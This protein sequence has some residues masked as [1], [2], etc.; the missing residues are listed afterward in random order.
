MGGSNYSSRS[1]LRR[2][3]LRSLTISLVASAAVRAQNGNILPGNNLI[4]DGIP[5][6]AISL[7]NT[8]A[9]YQESFADSLLG[10]DPVKP[11]MI[12]IRQR[13]QAWEIGRIA[14]AGESLQRFAY[15]P[16]GCYGTHYQPL[17]ESLIFRIDETSG[18]EVTQLYRY[19]I[20]TRSKTLLTDG[21]SRNLYP[22][23]SN[24]GEWLM[25]SS[26]RRN[27]KDLDIYVVKPSDPKS[28]RMIAQLD[29]EDWA[30]FDW[31]PD[32]RKAIISDYKSINE[33]YLWILDIESGKKTL[34]TPAQEGEKVFNG[35]NAQFSKDNKGVYHLTD[36][37]SE[38]QRLA[39]VDIATGRYTYI[40]R[41]IQWDV[42]D[43]ALSRDRN[44]LAFI[45][46]EEGISRVHLLDTT[47]GKELSVPKLPTGVITE[48]R[49]HNNNNYLGFVLS[50][51]SSP[52]DIY[53]LDVKAGKLERWTTSQTGGL[54]ATTLP[55]PELIKWK[56]FDGRMIP[57]F[58]YGP[59]AKHSGKRPVLIDIHGGPWVQY[60]PGFRGMDNYF[61][62]EL[63]IAM[64]YPNVRGS[65]GYGKTYLKLDNGVLRE[66]SYKDIAALLDW[67]KTQPDLD[68]DRVLVRGASSGGNAALA[69]AADHST[70]IRGAIS[71]SAPSNLGTLLESLDPW[72]Q[73]RAREEYGDE[74]DT[75]VRQNL[76]KIAPLTNVKKIKVPLLLIHGKLDA[77]IPVAQS[78]TMIA[79]AKGEKIPVWSLLIKNE[80]HG[81][82]DP[83]TKDYV[84]LSQVTF[85]Q[86]YLLAQ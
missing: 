74:R 59:G 71:I 79:A 56:S 63:G 51:T 70:K 52:G 13:P 69:V 68:A 7:A 38:F 36:R 5:P 86:R 27:G 19:D 40:T 18:T 62:S 9:P 53:S 67:I 77:R 61:T 12:A 65:S 54:E 30:A 24:S 26:T 32:D 66:N 75:K 17:G 45:T 82:G 49:W 55:E 64:I 39:Y 72:R 8:A 22:I 50:S 42:E 73:G 46:N 76:E 6:I 29:G 57:G 41:H 21:K 43:F 16:G 34:L 10:W 4:V 80:G 83:K 78:E 23:W 28:D 3:L 1:H 31:S 58:L 2:L 47:T 25:Y 44:L 85:I 35:P 33:S 11:E 14:T 81:F 48:L 84:F 20:A 37:D 60:R 15:V